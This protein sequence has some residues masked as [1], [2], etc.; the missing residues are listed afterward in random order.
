MLV[1]LG[2]LY[3]NYKEIIKSYDDD[4]DEDEED[5]EAPYNPQLDVENVDGDDGAQKADFD[6]LQQIRELNQVA[7]SP[8]NLSRKSINNRVSKN[9]IDTK[10]KHAQQRKIEAKGLEQ[11]FKKSKTKKWKD[12]SLARA[13]INPFRKVAKKSN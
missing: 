13:A 8:N 3:D 1:V 11:M 10:K 4:N 12:T 6:A 9:L 5:G 2:T 7:V